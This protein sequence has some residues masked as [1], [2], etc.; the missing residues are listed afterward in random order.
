MK[1]P[2]A[3]PGEAFFVKVRR[4][5]TDNNFTNRAIAEDLL[6]L[7]IEE[8]SEATES[9][10]LEKLQNFYKVPQGF[11]AELIKNLQV[12]RQHFTIYHSFYDGRKSLY[13]PKDAPQPK[14]A[15]LHFK[16][17]ALS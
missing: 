4:Q 12:Y 5:K 13:H 17:S 10:S 9:R 2:V 7:G 3:K 6:R 11:V 14:K 8:E 15:R 1:L 16:R